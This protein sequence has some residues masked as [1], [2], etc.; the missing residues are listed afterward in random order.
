MPNA[1]MPGPGGTQHHDAQASCRQHPSRILMM[2][3]VPTAGDT[4]SGWEEVMGAGFQHSWSGSG[5]GAPR[6]VEA[7]DA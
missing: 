7:A 6:A 5:P 1:V 3:N 4:V 2:P